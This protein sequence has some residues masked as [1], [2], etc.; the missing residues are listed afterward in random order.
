[1]GWGLLYFRAAEH[2]FQFSCRTQTCR[3]LKVPKP[4]QFTML[5]MFMSHFGEF[6]DSS[7]HSIWIFQ[8]IA[9]ILPIPPQ[10]TQ[11]VSTAS[12]P[13][14]SKFVPSSPAFC[15]RFSLAKDHHRSLL[16]GLPLAGLGYPRPSLAPGLLQRVPSREAPGQAKGARG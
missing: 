15:I 14:P 3:L 2:R 16:G 6:G 8:V 7:F 5:L 13:I 9:S 11:K 10:N 1:M 4:W 12:W